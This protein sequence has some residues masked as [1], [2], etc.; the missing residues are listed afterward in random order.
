MLPLLLLLLAV[1]AGAERFALENSLLEHLRSTGST[2]DIT[3]S[4]KC[5]T[6]IRGAFAARDFSGAYH[7]R[8]ACA[9][10]STGTQ[11]LFIQNSFS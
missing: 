6:C 8:Q 4:A 2:Y 9:Q 5:D 11:R 10:R 3:I 7:V 1:N